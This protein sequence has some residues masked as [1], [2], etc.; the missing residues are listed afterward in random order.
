M[1][2]VFERAGGWCTR[3]ERPASVVRIDRDVFWC[4]ACLLNAV[5]VL[6]EGVA[7]DA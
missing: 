3:C 2:V 4:M 6:S 1:Y 7:D 5:G